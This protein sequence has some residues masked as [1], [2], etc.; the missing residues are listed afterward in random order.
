MLWKKFIDTIFSY[1]KE[2]W[3]CKYKNRKYLFRWCSD[4]TCFVPAWK[5]L[6]LKYNTC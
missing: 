4:K 1:L 5:T 6:Y 3:V 2:P